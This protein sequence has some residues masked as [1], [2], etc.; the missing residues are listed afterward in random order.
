MTSPLVAVC[1]E[2]GRGHP[3]YL[4]SVLR[5]LAALP[6]FKPEMLSYV[7]CTRLER[8]IPGLA[9]RAVRQGYRLGAQGGVLTWLYNHL[10][11]PGARPSSLHLSLLGSD[12]RREL[13]GY[14]GICL[15]DHPLLA[16]ILSR[17]CR[18]AYLHAEIAA[19]AFA[20]VPDAWQTFVPLQATSLKLQAAGV[21]PEALAVTG[22]VIEPELVDRAESAF[23][24]RIERLRSSR[25]LTVGFFVSGAYPHPHVSRILA[26]TASVVTAGHQA[27]LFWGTGW[28]RAARIRG[29]LDKFG[30]PEERARLVWANSLQAETARTVELFPQLDLMVAA[31]HERTSWAVGLGLPMFALL[32]NIG[33]FAPG[34][35][36]FAVEQGV[37]L[38]IGDIEDARRL[39]STLGELRD[40]GRL[41]EMARSGYGRYPVDGAAKTVESLVR[42]IDPGARNPVP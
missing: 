37:C 39:G 10:R 22:L 2:I 35:Y 16:H 12:L 27:L 6:R 13:D 21:R 5:S 9:W 42:A 20:A 25:P 19:P 11:T 34:N 24:T 17:T 40:S 26:A 8:G 14:D 28:L 15:V 31:A 18:V 38:P 29:I 32:P 23:Q 33:P 4:N 3:A 1:S 36:A 7:P 41:L 30:V